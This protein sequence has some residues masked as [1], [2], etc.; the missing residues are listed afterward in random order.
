MGTK[1]E[2]ILTKKAKRDLDSIYTYIAKNLKEEN[3]AKRLMKTIQER[4]LILEDMPEGFSIVRFYNKKKY[5]Y[6]KLVVNN[7]IVIYRID[8]NSKMVYIVKIAYKGKNY[9]NEQ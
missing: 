2:V 3:A 9:L 1:Y 6:R 4:V 5:E 8:N 7:F